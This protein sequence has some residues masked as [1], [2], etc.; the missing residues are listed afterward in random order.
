MVL[1]LVLNIW[2]S[3][4]L[5][6]ND[7][8]RSLEKVEDGVIGQGCGEGIRIGEKCSNCVENHG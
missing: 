5:V 2:R 1:V 6:I 8:I 7:C 4:V 3:V